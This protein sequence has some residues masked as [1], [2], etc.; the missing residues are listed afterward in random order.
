MTA[1]GYY[2][3]QYRP[4]FHFSPETGWMNDPNGLVYYDGEYHLFYQFYPDS[5]VWGPMHWGHAVS[6]DLLHW[7]HLPI[8]LYPD[9]LG[10]IFSGSAVADV[11]NTSGFGSPG[12]PPLVAMFTY[13]NPILEK[14]GSKL[15]QNQGI[16]YSNDQGR[17]WTKYSGNP[18]LRNPGFRD[19][20]DPKLFWYEKTK[21]WVVIL[22][23]NDRVHIYS[24]P[25]MKDWKFESE[26]GTGIGAH[27]G[28]W[29][30]PDLFPLK[31]EGTDV[32]KWV[33]LVSINPGGPNGGSATQYFTGEFDGHKYVP[34]EKNIRWIDWGRDNYAGVTWSNIP[35]SDGRRIFIGWM[36]NWQYATV[37][38][39]KVWR[40][41]STIPRELSVASENGH[42]FL[43]SKPIRE[44]GDLRRKSDTFTI[45]RQSFTGEQEI[46][47]GSVELMQSELF[48]GFDLSDLKADTIGIILENKVNEK[49]ILGYSAINKEFY[50]DRREAGNPGF[51][52]E[53]AGI[54]SAPC[55]SGAVLK[56]HLLIDASSVE[57]FV[58]DGRLVMTNLVFPTE[59]FSKLKLFSR[60]GN[61]TLN[62][63]VFHGIER[64]WH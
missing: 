42:Y 36:S 2:R 32:M 63:A 50:I 24:S 25:D 60:G 14:S 44:L 8:A 27:A 13:H 19:F 57:L 31:V 28:V 12:N 54:S 15:F 41:A 47:A 51:S 4:Q 34:D 6:K 53:F 26:F 48:F 62:K 55:N 61:G 39:T 49:L 3:E 9:S 10:Y 11:N 37:V 33:M 56:L 29:E 52:K 7:I 18:V 46:S 59:K 30:C 58:D 17:T 1:A 20:R 21:K 16:A 45:T 5:T 35:E 22:A 23:V 38:P 64:I 40:S 43:T